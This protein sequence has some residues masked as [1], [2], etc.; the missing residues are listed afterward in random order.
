MIDKDGD[1][2]V[3]GNQTLDVYRLKANSDK[4]LTNDVDGAVVIPAA[5]LLAN[6]ALEWTSVY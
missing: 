3:A 4:V 5:V 1:D 6:D 2:S